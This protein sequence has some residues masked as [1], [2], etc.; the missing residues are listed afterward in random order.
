[1]EMDNLSMKTS[2]LKEIQTK[3]EPD[4]IKETDFGKVV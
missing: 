3:L 1:M 4:Y 2:K